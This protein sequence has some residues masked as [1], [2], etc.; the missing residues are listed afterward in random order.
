[1]WRLPLIL[2]LAGCRF[3]PT[4]LTIQGTSPDQSAGASDLAQPDLSNIPYGT[5]AAVMPDQKS[6]PDLLL[7]PAACTSCSG[8]TCVVDCSDSKC[9]SGTSLL[10]PTGWSCRIDCT[11]TGACRNGA[12]SCSGNCEIV[13][14]GTA[15]CEYGGVSCSG[16]AC[17]VTCDGTDACDNGVRCNA[18][19]C[20]VSCSGTA[21][22]EDRGVCCNGASCGNACTATAGGSC[23]CR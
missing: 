7:C 22:C 8:N 20:S 18:L 9:S 21:A 1:M 16:A 15:A 4:G 11:G 23:V 14:S 10:C 13:C 5:D 17:K 3:E 6:V 19:V 2:C 12:V